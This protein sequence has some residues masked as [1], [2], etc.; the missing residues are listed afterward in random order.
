MTEPGRD[1]LRELLDAVLAEDHTTLDAMAAGAASS[2]FH[3]SRLLKRDAGEPPV[4]LRRRVMLERAAWQVGTGTSVTDAAWAAGYESVEGFR[5]AFVRA[6]GHP[7]G[8]TARARAAADHWL[9]APNGIHF[10]PPTSLW[11]HPSEHPSMTA[12]SDHLVHHDVDDT[13]AL[14]ALAATLDEEVFRRSFL[15][16]GQPVQCWDGVD[17]SIAA[18]LDNLVW[19]KE[20]WVAAIDGRDIPDRGAS[21]PATLAARHDAAAADWLA[22]VRDIDRRDAWDD[23]IVDAL[24]DPPERFVLGSIVAHVI[25]YDAHRRLLLRH[26]LRAFGIEVDE[27]DPIEWLRTREGG[28]S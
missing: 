24:C 15:L 11:V 28:T 12:V 16:A 13:R 3:F 19:T 1:R 9:S 25:T 4:A 22:L 14:I 21:D 18:I 27:G 2:P 23:S 10:H 17:E 7:P 20:V 5:R 26:V 6:Y 8:A